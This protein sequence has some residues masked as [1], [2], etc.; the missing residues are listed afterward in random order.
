MTPFCF[1]NYSGQSDHDMRLQ[2]LAQLESTMLLLR[3]TEPESFGLEDRLAVYAVLVDHCSVAKAIV[4]HARSRQNR[5]RHML[6]EFSD[7]HAYLSAEATPALEA[8]R[9]N[10]RSAARCHFTNVAM[11]TAADSLKWVAVPVTFQSPPLA[12]AVKFAAVTAEGGENALVNDS[13]T[14]EAGY[15]FRGSRIGAT[16]DAGGASTAEQQCVATH[17]AMLRVIA[18][19][20]LARRDREKYEVSVLSMNCRWWC[21]SVL[22]EHISRQR[23][24]LSLPPPPF[25]NSAEVETERPVSYRSMPAG[26]DRSGQLALL[27]CFDVCA[28]TATRTGCSLR[29]KR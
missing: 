24:S 29:R 9:C 19:R 4:G 14:G 28:G 23:M 7:Q 27:N 25:R 3:A 11:K 20:E 18:A 16:T 26:F 15:H 22:Q 12:T 13:E 1:D 21:S 5:I 6:G 10:P 8:V 2:M 17:P